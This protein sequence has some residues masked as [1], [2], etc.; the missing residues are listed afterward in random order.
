MKKKSVVK[1]K[2]IV[3]KK[4]TNKQYLKQLE[5]FEDFIDDLEEDYPELKKEIKAH[6]FFA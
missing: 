2:P 3:K 1:K 4:L 5:D 6:I